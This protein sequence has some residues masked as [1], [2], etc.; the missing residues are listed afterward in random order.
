MGARL[1]RR[2]AATGG[3]RNLD[4]QGVGY[5]V[6]RL[7]L[8]EERNARTEGGRRGVREH[9]QPPAAAERAT[10]QKE[11]AQPPQHC[12]LPPEGL[13]A[14]STVDFPNAANFT[15]SGVRGIPKRWKCRLT[16]GLVGNGSTAV[17]WG[18][19]W[20]LGMCPNPPPQQFLIPGRGDFAPA[21][22]TPPPAVSQAGDRS[23]V[24]LET[25]Q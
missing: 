25:S 21:A 4:S 10:R 11:Q 23:E 1:P 6:G 12:N 5:R 14:D 3:A 2:P 18:W 20:G 24:S 19:G 7:C 9:R 13:C 15:G 16:G 22:N 8:L 17:G